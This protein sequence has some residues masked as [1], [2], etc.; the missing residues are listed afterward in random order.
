MRQ[1]LNTLY[2]TSQGAYLAREGETVVV[3]LERE[4][5]L[6]IPIHNLGSIVCFG[7]VS[8]SPPLMQLCGERQVAISFLSEYGR[9]WAR[10]EGPVSGNVFLRREQYRR[11]DDEK[12][13]AE[14][15]RAVVIAKITNCRTVILRAIRDR[16]ERPG[17][18]DMQAAADRMA[19]LLSQLRDAAPLAMIR[20]CE[21]E[22]ARKY[23]G[24]FD[25]L[26]S[27]QKESFYFQER[28]RRPP[29]DNMNSLLSFLYTLLAHDVRSA[30]ETVGLDPAV[31]FLHRDRPGRPGLALDV[32]EEFRPYLAD[33]LALSLVN[34]QQVKAKGF[35]S[36]ETGAVVMDDET[37]KEVLTSYQKRKQEEIQHPFLGERLPLGMLPYVQAMLMARHLRGDLDAYPPFLWK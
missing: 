30:L 22:A 21:G 31:G 20:G 6:R 17:T 33:R 3:R 8:C 32:M 24:V 10:M 34:R 19:A 4:T 12:H 25:H 11:A 1:L 15:A 18:A 9:F 28:N 27:S 7:Q 2:V 29:L 36:S 5:K 37:R 23:F 16:P 14:I 35:A 13:S 26:I